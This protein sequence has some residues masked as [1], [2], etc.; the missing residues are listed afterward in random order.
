MRNR[1]FTA[2]QEKHGQLTQVNHPVFKK[3]MK[4]LENIWR[5]D[6][7]RFETEMEKFKQP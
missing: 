4:R 3:E 5:K 6:K 2:L 1:V 7:V